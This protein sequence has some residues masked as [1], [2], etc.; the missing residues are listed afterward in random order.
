MSS[1]RWSLTV[2]EHGLLRMPLGKR[3]RGSGI[4]EVLRPLP[5]SDLRHI[6]KMFADIVV[7][8]LQ[9]LVEEVDRILRLQ[10]K[11]GYVLQRIQCK[12]E[13]AHFI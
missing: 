8:T 9:F 6:L 4:A 11:T 5:I 1:A 2:G 7:V 13:A 12:V 3:S 10:T